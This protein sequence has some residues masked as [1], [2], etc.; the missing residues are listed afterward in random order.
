MEPIFEASQNLV[1]ATI[2][3]VPMKMLLATAA[4]A[5][6]LSARTVAALNLEQ[7]IAPIILTSASG[8][9]TNKFVT[10]ST[11]ALGQ[12]HGADRRMMVSAPGLDFDGA[13]SG[14]LLLG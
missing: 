2:N 6:Q 4:S 13:V 11:I 14:D 1:P 5:T 9:V 10:V 7:H 8:A 3:G 12:L